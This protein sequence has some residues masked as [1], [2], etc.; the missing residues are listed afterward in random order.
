MKYPRRPQLASLRTRKFEM[1]DPHGS[2]ANLHENRPAVERH[3]EE[4]GNNGAWN[5]KTPVVA[6]EH[7]SQTGSSGSSCLK[8]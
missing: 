7:A 3:A 8:I 5:Q 6:N 2:V 1:Q 4:G